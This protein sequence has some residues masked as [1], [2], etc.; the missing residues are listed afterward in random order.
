MPTR[1]DTLRDHRIHAGV[2]RCLRLLDRTDL[3]EDLHLVPVRRLDERSGLAPE[4]DDGGH[5]LRDRRLHQLPYLGLV[6][7]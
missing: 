6:L 1:L 5:P 7:L 3:D 2:R 4:Q